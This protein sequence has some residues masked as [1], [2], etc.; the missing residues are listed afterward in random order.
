[1][2]VHCVVVA[3]AFA[4]DY[5]IGATTTTTTTRQQQHKRWANVAICC[6]LV[7]WAFVAR[8]ATCRTAAANTVCVAF[9]ALLLLLFGQP[10]PHSGWLTW[11]WPKLK[12][13]CNNKWA[14]TTLG[15]KLNVE[16]F[17]LI[18]HTICLFLLFIASSRLFYCQMPTE[19]IAQIICFFGQS[20]KRLT[21]GELKLSTMKICQK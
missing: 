13:V 8:G 12:L 19:L 21:S 15:N 20:L 11:L 1:M 5:N 10:P 17:V 16:Y 4:V 3:A 18:G 9:S 7:L 2:V 6:L 14:T